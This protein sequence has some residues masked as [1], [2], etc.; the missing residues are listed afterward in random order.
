M[1]GGSMSFRGTK[2]CK[3]SRQTA[4]T[5]V[6]TDFGGLSLPTDLQFKQVEEMPALK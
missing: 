5:R 1:D 2:E 3:L 6:A 4:A